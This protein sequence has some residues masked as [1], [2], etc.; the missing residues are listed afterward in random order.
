MGYGENLVNFE[1]KNAGFYAFLLRKTTCG[2]KP[3]PG[4]GGLISPTGRGL[5]WPPGGW[6]CKTDM[7]VENLAG[8]STPQLLS[9][10]TLFVIR[11]LYRFEILANAK[12]SARQP[13]W[14]KTHFDMKLA[15][16]VILGHYFATSYRQTRGSILPC[17]IAGFISGVSEEVATKNRQQL[18]SST[19]PANIPINLIFS[20]TR[21]IG[22]HFCRW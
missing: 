22:L 1:V 20:E 8:G 12:V 14:S 17:N 2:Q 15:L 21:F 10:C 18:P 3:G 11:C 13:C 9:I 19:T 5:Y 7:G 4:R 16:K 6:R